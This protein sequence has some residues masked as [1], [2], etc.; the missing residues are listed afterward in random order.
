VPTALLADR[1]SALEADKRH[2]D[3]HLIRLSASVTQQLSAS[4]IQ[5]LAYLEQYGHSSAVKCAWQPVRVCSNPEFSSMDCMSSSTFDSRNSVALPDALASC[6]G[7]ASHRW[8]ASTLWQWLWAALCG[9]LCKV[10]VCVG[11]RKRSSCDDKPCVVGSKLDRDVA[12]AHGGGAGAGSLT[13]SVN[14]N[15]RY[16]RAMHACRQTDRQAGR[17]IEEVDLLDWMML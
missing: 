13:R 3:N 16:W 12:A 9:M 2:A 7:Q 10:Q 14:I 1:L 6:G 5:Q 11:G 17:Q 8:N 4:I 15:S